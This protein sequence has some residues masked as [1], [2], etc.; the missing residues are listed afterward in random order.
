VIESKRS[1]TLVRPLDFLL[2]RSFDPECPKEPEIAL[3]LLGDDHGS[4]SAQGDNIRFYILRLC[5]KLEEYYGDT[6]VARLIVPRGEYRIVLQRP[7]ADEATAT[8]A[9]PIVARL[10]SRLNRQQ[11]LVLCGIVVA[12]LA[13][14]EIVWTNRASA[15]ASLGQTSLWAPLARQAKATKVVVADYFLFGKRRGDGPPT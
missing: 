15:P 2:E 12:N 11:A 4:M 3:A 14:A 10:A 6:L 13:L 5:G 9:L 1:D 8:P 7:A